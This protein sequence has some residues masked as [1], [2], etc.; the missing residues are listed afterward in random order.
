[1]G[2]YVLSAFLDCQGART[3]REGRPLEVLCELTSRSELQTP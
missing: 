2:R 1:M 3:R